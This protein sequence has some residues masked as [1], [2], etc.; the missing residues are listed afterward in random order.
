MKWLNG[1]GFALALTGA[2]YAATV[3]NP[4]M[5]VDRPDPSIVRVDDAY[6]MVTTT[7]HLPRAFRFSRARIWRSGVRWVMCTRR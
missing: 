7:M 3:N 6:Y 4:I 1:I 2:T 5:Y